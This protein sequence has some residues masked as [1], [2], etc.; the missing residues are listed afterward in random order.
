[1][2]RCAREFVL[3]SDCGYV[4]YVQW[5]PTGTTVAALAEA[6]DSD[7]SFTSGGGADWSS[8][9]TTYFH[10]GDAAKSG[11]IGDYGQS[12][13]QTTV[14]G[15]GIVSFYWKVSSQG[16]VDFL[17]F[18]IDGVRQDGIGGTGEWQK[19]LFTISG[20]GTHTL[21]W[22]YTKDDSGYSGSDCA[23]VDYVQ[24]PLLSGEWDTVSYTYGP[25]GRRIEKKYD[26]QAVMKYLY[27]GGHIIAEYDAT[28]ALVHKYIY[29]PGVDQPICMIDVSDA[30]AAYY[31]HFD[32]LGSVIALTDSAGAVANLYEYSI[33]GEVSASDPNHPNRF[34][35]TGREFDSETGLYYYRARYYNPY[36]GRFLQTDPVGYGDGMNSYAYCANRPVGCSDPFGCEAT[37][38]SISLCA[39]TE[40]T[41]YNSWGMRVTPDTSYKW[42]TGN[43]FLDALV[44][45]TASYGEITAL[46]IF[47]HGWVWNSPE[48]WRHRGG[49]WGQ[50]RGGDPNSGFYGLSKRKDSAGSRDL[51]DLEELIGAGSIKFAEG[52]TIFMNACHAANTGY[53]AR[54]LAMTTGCTVYAATGKVREYDLGDDS[55][56]WLTFAEGPETEPITWKKFLPDGTEVDLGTNLLAVTQDTTAPV[57]CARVK[58]R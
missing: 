54:E 2:V 51:D 28:G 34:L 21:L 12:W 13:M 44:S 10:D 52:G 6:V 15:E 25:G 27:D 38:T 49:V 31:Y 19:K 53:F 46:N 16:S 40:G 39:I 56:R 26:G 23:W 22:R 11:A 32:G 57:V 3:S 37:P 5:T 58:P 45:A 20:S 14:Q 9:S 4:D 48:G 36:I 29:G 43:N 50:G 18:L 1:M 7:L 24:W 8:Q 33:F 42:E 41:F 55:V 30:N 17:E 35:F 47:S